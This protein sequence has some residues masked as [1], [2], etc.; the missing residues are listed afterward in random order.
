MW[1]DGSHGARH[2]VQD[3]LQRRL[4]RP[5]ARRVLQVAVQPGRQRRPTFS[6][7]PREAA[8]PHGA[9]SPVLDD[10]EVEAGEVS[11]DEGLQQADDPTGIELAVGVCD[12][13]TRQRSS[14]AA[15]EAHTHSR[16][17]LLTF[18]LNWRSRCSMY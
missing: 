11:G 3:F 6:R 2:A 17:G 9:P 10:A 8:A 12:L 14:A 7:A 18:M 5:P 15:Q 1:Q 4:T 13:H 16:P